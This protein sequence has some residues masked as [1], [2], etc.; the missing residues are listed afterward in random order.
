ML[1]FIP[2]LLSG[3][4]LLSVAGCKKDN[5]KPNDQTGKLEIVFRALWDGQPL[6][7]N[8]PQ[9]YPGD[10]SLRFAE[11][12]YFLTNVHLENTA[13]DLHTLFE[14]ALVDFQISNTTA[15]G[16]D[17]GLILSLENIPSGTYPA[18]HLGIGLDSTLNTTRPADY[19]SGHPM[20]VEANRYWDAWSSYI[21]SK[22]QGLADTTG[23]GV[24]D[25]PFAYHVGGNSLYRPLT[26]AGPI[27]ISSGGTT[28]LVFDLEVKELFA[29]GAGT[30][31]DIDGSPT[32]H[33][34]GSPA[35]LV[36]MNNY[37][38]ALSMRLL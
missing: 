15:N 32:A 27:T 35:M 10:L 12:D 21:F 3:A 33:N 19:P 9:P 11:V 20:G 17:A 22:L 28:R 31:W 7:L 38:S 23:D 1:R 26:F 25:K 2:L 6:V 29:T 36:I 5:D 16:A 30:Y 18:M 37:Q 8:S 24:P 4:V 14:L 13:G 34:E